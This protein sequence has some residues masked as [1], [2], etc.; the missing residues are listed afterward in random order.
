MLSDEFL[1]VNNILFLPFTEMFY[2]MEILI[3]PP[4]FPFFTKLITNIFGVSVYSL[5]V[6]ALLFSCG[7]LILFYPLLNKVFKNKI[8]IFFGLL[9]FS[10]NGMLIYYASE[11]KQ[12]SSEVFFCV[13]LL[14]LFDKFKTDTKKQILFWIIISFISP[15]FAFSSL[16]VLPVFIL[17]RLSEKNISIK[18]KIPYL[19]IAFSLLLAFGTLYITT[20]N[21]QSDM[22]HWHDSR[23][24]Q[25]SF[26]NLKFALTEFFK[27]LNL[28]S[29]FI[30]ITFFAG[31]IISNWN[32]LVKT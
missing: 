30:L 2:K 31:I 20:Y 21:N 32:A 23:Y 6:L 24:Y 29:K 22:Y 27:Y 9:L 3:L 4:F 19:Y 8:C 7:S 11:C 25:F 1:L 14:F 12:Y 15:F 28:Y 13:L 10:V 18:N 26:Y 5:R 17:Y 16:F